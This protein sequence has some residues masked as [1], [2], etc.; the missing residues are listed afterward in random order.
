MSFNKTFYSD[1]LSTKYTFE[2]LLFP[3]TLIFLKF[4]IL[5]LLYELIDLV[6]KFNC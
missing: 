1:I 2:L 5:N 3:I 4:S 6:I